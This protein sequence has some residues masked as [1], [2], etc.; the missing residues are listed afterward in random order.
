M[1]L[2]AQLRLALAHFQPYRR[3]RQMVDA[4]QRER[5]RKRRERAARWERLREAENTVRAVELQY[6]PAARLDDEGRRIEEYVP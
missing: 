4:S 6:R 1:S 5:A 2:L 3:V